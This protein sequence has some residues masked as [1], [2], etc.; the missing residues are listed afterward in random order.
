[1][2]YLAVDKGDIAGV[3]GQPEYRTD[4]S[5]HFSLNGARTTVEMRGNDV[6]NT[7]LDS[8]SNCS[9]EIRVSISLDPGCYEVLW[10]WEISNR[11]NAIA[12]EAAIEKYSPNGMQDATG[13]PLGAL[14]LTPGSHF[15]NSV[16]TLVT[17]KEADKWLTPDTLL[18]SYKPTLSRSG[19]KFAPTFSSTEGRINILRI[20]KVH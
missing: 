14:R 1:M 4:G 3:W 13:D 15:G 6:C 19:S 18:A 2:D 9:G 7:I 17:V 8:F 12:G 10:Q 5:Y 16:T 11:G 20:K